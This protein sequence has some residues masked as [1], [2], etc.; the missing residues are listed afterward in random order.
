MPTTSAI[1]N[2][3]IIFFTLLSVSIFSLAL[4]VMASMD[5]DELLRQSW[6]AY[7]KTLH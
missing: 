4:P 5:T 3:R 6:T 1:R 2:C 7:K